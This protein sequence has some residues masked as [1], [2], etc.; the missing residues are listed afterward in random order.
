MNKTNYQYFRAFL[1]YNI[2]Y[3]FVIP[4]KPWQR[5]TRIWYLDSLGNIIEDHFP[6]WIPNCIS[7]SSNCTF[8]I[9]SLEA[10]SIAKSNGITL[11]KKEKII[12]ELSTARDKDGVKIVWV[13]TG[14]I[15]DNKGSFYFIDISNG[16]VIS[17]DSFRTS[18]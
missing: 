11:G 2:Y 3:D 18:H 15:D 10:I 9:D 1:H 13:V 12:A 5:I 6:E 17:K 14:Y 4:E 7:N 16:E 8:D